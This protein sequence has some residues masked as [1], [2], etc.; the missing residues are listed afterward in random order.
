[1]VTDIK[2]VQRAA[3]IGQQNETG[4]QTIRMLLSAPE[5]KLLAAYRDPVAWYAALSPKMR[6]LTLL[7]LKT[8][9]DRLGLYVFSQSLGEFTEDRFYISTPKQSNQFGLVFG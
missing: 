4:E 8:G 7:W 3:P 6:L 9:D 1:M 5:L 2:E